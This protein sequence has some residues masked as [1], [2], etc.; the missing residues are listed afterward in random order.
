MRKYQPELHLRR[1]HDVRKLMPCKCGGL[2]MRG[3]M[4]QIGDRHYHGRCAI[5][6]YG[7]EQLCLMEPE[8]TAGL[9]LDD[10]GPDNMR[11]LL[12]RIEINNT[13]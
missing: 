11:K 2:G 9:T 7:I 10:I 5:V 3:N 8:D 12:D 13:N 6:E 1:A 4:V